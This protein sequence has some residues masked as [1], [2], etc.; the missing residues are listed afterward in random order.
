[1]NLL[2][3]FSLIIPYPGFIQAHASISPINPSHSRYFIP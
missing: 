1:M 3:R 2:K